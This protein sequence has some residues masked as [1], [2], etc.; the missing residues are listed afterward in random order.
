MTRA[1]RLLL[2]TVAGNAY[3]METHFIQNIQRASFVQVARDDTGRFGWLV[4]RTGRRPVY[5]VADHLHLPPT[6]RDQ[7]GPLLVLQPFLGTVLM[8][9]HIHRVQQ[10]TADQIHSLPAAALGPVGHLLAGIFHDGNRLIP[11]IRPD[12]N[13]ASHT[14]QADLEK[15]ARN[16]ALSL[17]QADRTTR[18][19]DAIQSMPR[20]LVTFT[21]DRARST[22]TQIQF[23]VNLAALQEVLEPN[24]IAPVHLPNSYFG[25]F[26]NWRGR[27]VPVLDLNRRLQLPRDQPSEQN[28]YLILRTSRPN[29]HVAMPA[30]SDIRI[31]RTLVGLENATH[32]LNLNYDLVAGV[33]RFESQYLVVPQLDRIAFDEE[34]AIS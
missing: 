9:Q 32:K 6:P 11:I 4:T 15:E 3:A 23:G 8:V 30:N 29:Q 13:S 12:I 24:T 17:E 5:D 25:G 20:G 22:G 16:S 10:I 27:P 2:F 7:P 26:L 1:E 28:R 34:F 21:T 19:T 18:E 31:H 14:T 33:Y